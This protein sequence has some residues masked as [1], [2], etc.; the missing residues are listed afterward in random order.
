MTRLCVMSVLKS[1]AAEEPGLELGPLIAERI[2]R[3]DAAVAGMRGNF[4]EWVQN[5]LRRIDAAYE[6]AM[7]DPSKRVEALDEIRAITHNIK[8]QG[9]TFGLDDLSRIAG[10]LNALLRSASASVDL[11]D[12]AGHI[13][14]L[15][16]ALSDATA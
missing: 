2:R 16:Q 6:C 13:G 5:D 7:R 12:A 15:K 8:G 1:I 11:A 14:A 4:I 9:G 10:D 3:A